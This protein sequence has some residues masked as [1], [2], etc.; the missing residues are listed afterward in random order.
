MRGATVV[1]LSGPIGLSD[2]ERNARG[3]TKRSE[4]VA[5]SAD[6]KRLDYLKEL[7]SQWQFIAEE[8]REQLAETGSIKVTP[9]GHEQ[10]SAA[11]GVLKEA[12][13][14]VRQLSLMIARLEAAL[15]ADSRGLSLD[16]YD[17]DDL[18][19]DDGCPPLWGSPRWKAQNPEQ[20]AKLNTG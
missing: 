19:A 3:S 5:L 10:R 2:D 16:D 6:R 11:L 18:H 17:L 14:Q 12:T 1:G 4:A 20:A 9:N 8:A 15:P 7:W 13:S